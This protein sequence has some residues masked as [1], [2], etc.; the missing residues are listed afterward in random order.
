[1]F[2]I[3][4]LAAGKRPFPSSGTPPRPA[5]SVSQAGHPHDSPASPSMEPQRQSKPYL[6]FLCLQAL[7]EFCDGFSE[8]DFW[9]DTNSR[10]AWPQLLAYEVVF[11]IYSCGLPSWWPSLQRGCPGHGIPPTR[12][13]WLPPRSSA[14]SVC[15][16]FA[17]YT[18]LLGDYLVFA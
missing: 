16:S 10:T 14:A 3:Y 12:I 2:L 15:Y 4:I 9:S 5:G 7:T 6:I 13:K 11:Q 18:G 17:H 8:L 1:M